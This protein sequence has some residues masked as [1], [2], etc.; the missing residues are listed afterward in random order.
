MCDDPQCH[1][2]DIRDLCEFS[3]Q[4]LAG[5]DWRGKLFFRTIT[6]L[7]S[8]CVANLRGEPWQCETFRQEL[9]RIK[10]M[11]QFHSAESK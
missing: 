1:L 11:V 10:Q 6:C 7:I 3:S 2:L 9:T 8:Q 4:Y 5:P